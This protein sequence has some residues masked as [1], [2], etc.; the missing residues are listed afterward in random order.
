MAL[1]ILE[2]AS[3]AGDQL[4]DPLHLRAA[5]RGLD[6]RHFVLES[7]DLGP[8]LARFAA[9][10]AVI[11]KRQ[12]LL[13]EIVVIRDEHASFARRDCLG[14][15]ERKRPEGAHRSRALAVPD[16]AQRFG[17]ALDYWNPVFLANC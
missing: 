7:D 3:L 6:V 5:D 8:E 15:M 17:G 12:Q 11:A 1:V 13:V 2:H 4:V 9:R 14:A 16:S 10:P